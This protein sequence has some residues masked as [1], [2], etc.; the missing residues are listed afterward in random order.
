MLTPEEIEKLYDDAEYEVC[1][2]QDPAYCQLWYDLD[3]Y[4]K[5]KL[6]RFAALVEAKALEEREALERRLSEFLRSTCLAEA[7]VLFDED[8]RCFSVRLDRGST[9]PPFFGEGSDY[10]QAL[11]AALDEA[12]NG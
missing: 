7:T 5:N 4:S 6:L 2:I 11:R 1:P 10:W 9:L 8:N 12:T 3:G